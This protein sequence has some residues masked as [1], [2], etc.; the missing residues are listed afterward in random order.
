[1]IASLAIGF[2][3]MAR[4]G[5]LVWVPVY[6]L[7]QHYKDSLGGRW[8]SIALPMGMAL[9]ALSSGWISDRLFGSRR[10]GVITAFMGI[11]AIASMAMFYVPQGHWAGVPILFLCG[12]FAYGPQSTFW[13]LAPD[14]LGTQRAG[15]GVGVMNT[16]AYVVAGLG[17]PLIGRII[18]TNNDNTALVFPIVAVACLLGA[19]TALFVRR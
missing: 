1:M 5:L 16:F 10:S 4:Y 18:E 9:G 14:L 17:E 3:N 13:A 11:A 6:F 15:T 8:V 2:Q 19:L 12:F 7:G